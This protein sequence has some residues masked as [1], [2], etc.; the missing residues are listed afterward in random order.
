MKLSPGCW[1]GVRV[2]WEP[3]QPPPVATSRRWAPWRGRWPSPVSART[4]PSHP[5]RAST[6]AFA[7]WPARIKG[8]NFEFKLW[9][10]KIEERVKRFCD[11][12]KYALRVSKMRDDPLPKCRD[13]RV[14]SCC[15]RPSLARCTPK[16]LPSKFAEKK[17]LSQIQRK[18]SFNRT[19]LD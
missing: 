15:P 12:S 1:V 8:N 17:N 13:R 7:V 19:V 2:C 18:K 16:P 4:T 3:S 14:A 6:L 10:F 5:V 11:D 9:I